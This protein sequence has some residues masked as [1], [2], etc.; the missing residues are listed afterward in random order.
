MTRNRATHASEAA[1]V[2]VHVIHP[3]AIYSLGE[4]QSALGL[5]KATL[6]REIRL[7]RLRVAKR[8]GKYFFLGAWIL[9]W[10]R[11]GER[12]RKLSAPARAGEMSLD[13]AGSLQARSAAEMR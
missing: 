6:P 11:E 3:H 12:P 7:G 13:G 8:A 1:P 2:S 5:P 4:A 10:I 9:Q